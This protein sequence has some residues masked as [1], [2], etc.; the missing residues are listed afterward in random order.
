MCVIPMM[1]DIRSPVVTGKPFRMAD[2]NGYVFCY[3]LV[4][5]SHEMDVKSRY[6]KRP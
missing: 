3:P 2:L 6:K 4:T 5:G 1:Y